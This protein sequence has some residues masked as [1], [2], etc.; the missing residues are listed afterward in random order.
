MSAFLIDVRCAHYYFEINH[1]AIYICPIGINSRGS[2]QRRLFEAYN[3]YNIVPT[4]F[5]YIHAVVQATPYH[6]DLRTYMV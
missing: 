4:I 3:K 1:K 5:V 2:V 6:V